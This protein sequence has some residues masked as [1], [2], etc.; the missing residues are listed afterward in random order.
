NTNIWWLRGGSFAGT[1][2]ILPQ[3]R[4]CRH[5]ASVLL[6]GLLTT[7]PLAARANSHGSDPPAAPVPTR[8]SQRP[9]VHPQDTGFLNRVIVLNG[10]SYRY[11]VYL[12][13]EY[14]PHRSW[15]VILFING[16]GERGSYGMDGA[17][18]GPP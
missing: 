17:K 16:S 3:M 4:R 1:C 18:G 8:E 7:I 2:G 5:L 6:A 13:V 15:P 10:V 11:V 9:A 14:D 12:P